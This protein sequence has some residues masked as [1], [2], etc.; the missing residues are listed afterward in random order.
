VSPD[1]E[2]RAAALREQ[3]SRENPE[4]LAWMDGM[5]SIFSA[6]VIH[7]KTDGIEM[8]KEPPPGVQPYLTEDDAGKWPYKVG[9]SPAKYY[10]QKK[11]KKR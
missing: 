2:A 11:G 7:V 8:G 10:T 6:V 1:R 9:E 3:L 5:K 4:M